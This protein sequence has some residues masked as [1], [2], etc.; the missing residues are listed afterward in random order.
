M[1]GSCRG[2]QAVAAGDLSHL[3]GV[4]GGALS[5]TS[6]AA[7]DPP[8]EN[9]AARR[10]RLATAPLPHLPRPTRGRLLHAPRPRRS[11]P[12]QRPPAP[13]R[14][15]ADAQRGVGGAAAPQREPCHLPVHRQARHRRQLW[16]IRLERLEN[17]QLIQIETWSEQ[18]S[19]DALIEALKA[20]VVAR[21][22]SFLGQP[23]IRATLTWTLPARRITITGKRSN[24]PFEELVS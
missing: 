19:G 8:S 12:P 7:Q 14:R 5:R 21:F 17:D 4:A 10:A 22:A 15:R 23:P 2:P 20:P 1:G 6:R 3:P 18:R 11:A 9:R 13:K 24:E 16:P